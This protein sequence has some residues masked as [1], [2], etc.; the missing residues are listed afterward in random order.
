MSDAQNQILELGL[1]S[2]WGG[3]NGEM[4]IKRYKLSVIR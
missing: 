1:L 3:E 4:F 2:F